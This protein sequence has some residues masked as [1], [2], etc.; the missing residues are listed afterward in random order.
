MAPPQ[1]DPTEVAQVG[2]AEETVQD[3]AALLKKAEE[4]AGIERYPEAAAL[5]KQVS[6][7]TLLTDYHKH[8]L[9]IAERA[10]SMK[11]ELFQEFQE[12]GWHK[13]SEIHGH[14]DTCIYYKVGEDASLVARIETLIE[15]SL[16]NPL[17]SVFNE[18]DLYQSW[19]PSFKMPRLGVQ[20]SEKMQESG[21]G[22]VR[23]PLGLSL[24]GRLCRLF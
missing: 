9:E 15:S 13:Q 2:K 6:D 19:M 18:S 4:T 12:G 17:L 22:N 21:R 1:E 14:R 16:L 7:S 8:V 5:L 3:D 10:E 11:K 24:S 23:E 20:L